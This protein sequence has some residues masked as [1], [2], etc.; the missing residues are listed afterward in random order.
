[1]LL[2]SFPGC[3]FQACLL[4][5]FLIRARCFTPDH[6]PLSHELEQKV[7]KSQERSLIRL[8]VR[9]AHWRNRKRPVTQSSVFLLKA[10]HPSE[11]SSEPPYKTQSGLGKYGASRKDERR[12][13]VY[14]SLRHFKAKRALPELAED[15]SKIGKSVEKL[16]HQSN[17]LDGSQ[18]LSSS[19][20]MEHNIDPLKAIN[21]FRLESRKNL[22]KL[23]LEK[24]PYLSDL[25]KSQ[26]IKPIN[27]PLIVPSKVE[28]GTSD[29]ALSLSLEDALDAHSPRKYPDSRL[30]EPHLIHL[31]QTSTIQLWIRKKWDV[32]FV[33]MFAQHLGIQE[34][35]SNFAL[36]FPRSGLYLKITELWKNDQRQVEEVEEWCKSQLNDPAEGLR[37]TLTFRKQL[38]KCSLASN[39]QIQ[40]RF[41][42]ENKVLS[43]DQLK[44]VE[45]A[46][47][48]SVD[49]SKI[50]EIP[51]ITASFN[52]DDEL[53]L[54]IRS[55]I[56]KDVFTPK[57][58]QKR[59]DLRKYLQSRGNSHKWWNEDQLEMGSNSL[60]IDIL[61]I[62]K[63]GDALRFGLTLV[64]Q[65][66]ADMSLISAFSQLV[67]IMGDSSKDL[68][69]VDSGER[70]WLY[71]NHPDFDQRLHSLGKSFKKM[72]VES[73]QEGPEIMKAME[74]LRSLI[75]GIEKNDDL[76]NVLAGYD[77]GFD[78]KI[79]AKIT[80]KDAQSEGI[81]N[82]DRLHEVEALN[83][84][85]KQKSYIRNC[86]I[87]HL[88]FTNGFAGFVLKEQKKLQ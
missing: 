28:D 19:T 1:M 51:T 75:P 29:R 9:Q 77:G 18:K 62:L 8:V 34:K 82:F 59:A 6:T 38:K 14:G 74:D 78:P 55:I 56:T 36:K 60:G 42:I 76:G 84:S 53:S 67:T 70:A 7:A 73:A 87:S 41:W 79:I 46:Y 49:P 23:K 13:F 27:K 32:S 86:I 63:L 3:K 25:A 22:P 80:S 43:L 50:K 68:P 35:T 5:I 71:A 44:Q 66:R 31:W 21:P 47:G 40:R 54:K 57:E 10:N 16:P 4:V 85:E 52:A 64:R 45:T 88:E 33:S 2:K 24:R 26:D 39:W 81:S 30:P 12:V 37:R 11:P 69:W 72:D 48:L 20:S 61:T 65:E 15:L 83:L 58:L 17:L